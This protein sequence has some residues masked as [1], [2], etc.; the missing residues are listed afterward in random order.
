MRNPTRRGRL[1]FW[2]LTPLALVAFGLHVH[3]V[4]RSGL[5][6]LPVWALRDPDGGY[7]RVGGYRVETDSSG[8]RL[9]PGDRLLSV[10]TTDLRGAGFIGFDAAA[11]A[12]TGPLGEA[13]LVFERDGVRTEGSIRA[14]ARPY[15]W[16][17]VPPL[18]ASFLFCALVLLRAPGSPDAQR[19]FAAVMSYGIVQAQFYGGPAW[20]TWLSLG[21]W[22]LGAPIASVLMLRW[23][24]YFP[25]EVA[26]S[27][28]PWWGWAWLG[29]ALWIPI[30]LSY[31]RGGPLP[32]AWLP[33]VSQALH[34]LF[35]V[36]TIALLLRNYA[37]A[38]PVGRRRLKWVLWGC[39]VGSAPLVLAQASL[40]LW[41]GW[42]GFPA[43][44]ALGTT[45]TTLA[46][47]GM[48]VAIARYNIF[49]IDRLLTATA[50]STLVGAA[51]LGGLL[52]VLPELARAL[53]AWAPI[54]EGPARA[55]LALALA[56]PL[57][58][59]YRRLRP[60]IERIFFPEQRERERGMEQLLHDLSQCAARSEVLDLVSERL[61]GV[62]RP[63]SCVV[64]AA[65]GERLEPVPV[66]GTAPSGSLLRRGPLTLA[67][68]RDPRPVVVD[69]RAFTRAV[70][71][72]APAERDELLAREA[73]VLVP[74]R[75][76]K[77]LAGFV[78]LGAPRSG[79]VY[80]SG[81][82]TL[83]AAL[84]QKASAELLHLRDAETIRSERGR[85]AEL[86]RLRV[87]AE[88]LLARRSRF[89]AAASHDLRQPL[90]A[91]RV[92]ASLLEERIGAGETRALVER[93]QQS[94]E[95]LSEMFSSLLDLSRLDVGAVEPRPVALALDPLLEGLC[96]ELAPS[97][98]AKG[99]ELQRE[100]SG[101]AV[102]SDPVLLG[103]IVRNLLTN[104]VLYTE[105]G[106]VRVVAR[107]RGSRVTV[108][109][110]DTGPGI[111]PER[112]A[113]VFREFVRLERGTGGGGGLG[114]GL[115][116]V[117]RLA[118]ALGHEVAVESE[119]GRGSTF[120]LTLPARRLT[121]RAPAVAAAAGLEGR[122]VLLVDDDLEVLAATRDRIT[123]WGCRV[124]AAASTAE[125]LEALERR[126]VRPEALLV[127]YRLAAATTGL[128]VVAAMRAAFGAALPA[129]L[130]SGE[131]T[132]EAMGR[133]RASGLPLLL[134]PAAPARLRAL[135]AELL[136]RGASPP[137]SEPG[138]ARPD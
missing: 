38:D 31:L 11:L 95:A 80:T 25:A 120:R 132:P 122:V 137:S 28:R 52:F 5:A 115:A 91:L 81:D 109:V 65:N 74:L 67:L 62:M 7:P 69:E 136:R 125:A 49:D 76:G 126:G 77:D 112:Q 133:I 127:D 8:S 63:R 94:A 18:V 20:Q 27:A 130:L 39:A 128:E 12:A 86:A 23:A 73:A 14:R 57:V 102:H 88:Q 55:L 78:V 34:A 83:L 53:A 89:L 138:S 48:L 79:D 22:N 21:I 43:A 108:E 106:R 13:R 118:Q 71:D 75:C 26:A 10:G 124:V 41:P 35:I 93:L 19:F 59:A 68:E 117:E 47:A 61:P 104:A 107:P 64:Y 113:E 3:E 119:P 40:L 9:L 121:R 42:Q 85:A 58:P 70:P 33:L 29:L 44:F 90:H 87:E 92:L 82:L 2:G 32:P 54:G 72:L 103:R 96:A 134:K 4:A 100:E 16:S 114:L 116:I 17:R 24:T 45:W 110:S 123:R 99:L 46:V 105:R 66:R 30:R 111:A 51:F 36:G 101:L 56:A 60:G 84:A 15:P 37:H 131:T 1:L 129:A 135:L 98:E 97:A 50:S 6:Q